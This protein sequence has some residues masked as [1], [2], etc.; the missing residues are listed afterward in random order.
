MIGKVIRQTI[1]FAL[2]M[3][4]LTCYNVKGSSA[5]SVV[6]E[7]KAVQGEFDCHHARKKRGRAAVLAGRPFPRPEYLTCTRPIPITIIHQKCSSEN[8]SGSLEWLL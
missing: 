2:S 4:Y 5:I 6:N 8:L 1:N 3:Q 7:K